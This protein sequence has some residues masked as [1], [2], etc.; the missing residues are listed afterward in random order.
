MLAA[1]PPDC[2]FGDCLPTG[3]VVAD[4]TL[5]E[6][7]AAS[8]SGTARVP[9]GSGTETPTVCVAR[10]DAMLTSGPPDSCSVNSVTAFPAGDVV[11]AD[12]MLTEATA[13]SGSDTSRVPSGSGT[14]TPTVCVASAGAMLTAGPP[15]SCSANS[16]TAVLGFSESVSD[17]SSPELDDWDMSKTSND[18]DDATAGAF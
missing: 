11:V 5:T 4:T 16:V 7:A 1:G 12:A 10:A 18:F 8:G 3:D 6:A 13:A 17:S 15:D 2:R 14:E 9:S